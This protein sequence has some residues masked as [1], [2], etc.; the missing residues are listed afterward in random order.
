M[1]LSRTGADNLDGGDGQD[2]FLYTTANDSQSASA[3]TIADFVSGTD[4]IGLEIGNTNGKSFS[5]I[6]TNA[7]TTATANLIEARQDGRGDV[8]VDL[9]NNGSADMLIKFAT[10][11]TLA[12]DGGDFAFTPTV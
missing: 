1:L 11:V 8:E 2:V 12:T 7:F 9:T 5:F 10:S 6:G 3:D 4:D